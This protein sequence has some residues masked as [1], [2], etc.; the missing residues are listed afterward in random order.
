MKYRDSGM[1]DENL[2]NSFF[3]P[4]KILNLM[5]IN[6]TVNLL[7]DIGCGYG[8]FLFPASK[9]VKQVIGIDIDDQMIRYCENQINE[10]GYKN[11]ELITGDI[12]QNLTLDLIILPSLIF[13]IVKN[14]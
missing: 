11:I 4:V 13:F 9:I 7:I 10:H 1:P 12:S 5:G 2:W 6:K 14:L 8:T 3:D